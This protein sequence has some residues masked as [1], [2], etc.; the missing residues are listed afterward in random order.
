MGAGWG[1][2]MGLE[3]VLEWRGAVVGV[4]HRRLE[5]CALRLWH[6]DVHLWLNSVSTCSSLVGF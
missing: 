2:T 5:S 6:D 4:R 3:K 1:L